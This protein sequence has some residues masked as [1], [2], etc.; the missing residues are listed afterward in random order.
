M[1]LQTLAQ[2]ADI[3][4]ALSAV[5]AGEVSTPPD[6][7]ARRLRAAGLLLPVD[8]DEAADRVVDA[9]GAG[10]EK[11]LW[12]MGEDFEIVNV[13]AVLDGRVL[14]HRLAG[15]EADEGSLV[16]DL[17][18]SGFALDHLLASGLTVGGGRVVAVQDLED[19]YA[20]LVGPEAYRALGVAEGGLV[21]I[22]FSDGAARLVAVADVGDD[23]AL[24]SDLSAG[25]SGGRARFEGI[26]ER[27]LLT[28][29]HFRDPLPPL[30]E[31]LADH[32]FVVDGLG[33][34]RSQ[35]ALDAHVFAEDVRHVM[36]AFDV[37]EGSARVVA[38]ASWYARAMLQVLDEQTILASEGG[39]SHDA[40]KGL[41]DSLTAAFVRAPITVSEVRRGLADP[42]LAFAAADQ[43]LV[44][45][46][47][48]TEGL[49][50]F[51]NT[52]ATP[53]TVPATRLERA[54]VAYLTGRYREFA[55]DPLAAE[56]HFRRALALDPDHS[57][58]M[59]GLAAA[60]ADR[61]DLE[62]ASSLLDRAGASDTHPL[63][64]PVA[65]AQVAAPAPKHPPGRNEPCWCGS[66]R[67]YKVCHARVST[68]PLPDRARGLLSR[69]MAWM[70]ATQ[71]SAIHS[72][73]N[74]GRAISGGRAPEAVL[75]DAVPDLL[76]FEGGGLADYLDRRSALIPADEALLAQQWLLRP[77]SLFEVQ[78]VRPG[79]GVTLRDVMTGDR[80]DVTEEAAATHLKAG[81]LVLARVA[82]LGDHDEI[83]GGAI[84]MRIGERDRLID[85][86][87]G[88]PGP[89]DMIIF[90]AGRYRTPTILTS[91]GE[92]L[93]SVT[94]VYAVGDPA[95]LRSELDAVFERTDEDCWSM[96]AEPEGGRQS[97]LATLTLEGQTLTADAMSA[98]RFDR[99]LA[100]LADLD[101]PLVEV[102]RFALRPDEVPVDGRPSGGLSE[103][104]LADNPE[105][106]AHVAELIAEYEQNW[107]DEPVTA[108]GGITPRA[109]VNDP[110][111][112]GDLIALLD[113]M[114]ADDS[115]LSMNGPRLKAALGLI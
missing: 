86:L 47:D 29:G 36:D 70:L 14:T 71:P 89:G 7:V 26:M 3:L 16:L 94:G 40:I 84:P 80:V 44:S 83:L 105:V 88:Q 69:A 20:I 74:L 112:R 75:I 13:A 91:D 63:R 57:Y 35:E 37:D 43:V 30:G 32:G 59:L 60:A 103:E 115:P 27:L 54:G 65:Q 19:A 23:R 28:T 73:L 12:S 102:S 92:Q 90:L 109:A 34:W 24:V 98:P 38:G 31:I 11:S 99:L 104:Q 97:V 6:E 10:P 100:V 72:L 1:P 39:P 17:D 76:L 64:M 49:K 56:E 58:A 18:F 113:S 52:L 110:T 78:D 9:V 46:D 87:S 41:T 79:I 81:E 101:V 68:T 2:P 82:P 95:R 50:L 4:D 22:A 15:T 8:D 85:L 42:W 96:L 93:V 55:G 108:L 48:W 114:P 62:T 53:T 21:G 106:L 61:G 77:R 66:G 111:R 33:L 45:E 5:M 107:I 25:L 67:K 51:C